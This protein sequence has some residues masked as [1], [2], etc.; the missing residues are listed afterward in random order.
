MEASIAFVLM[1]FM[2][3]IT[4]KYLYNEPKKPKDKLNIALFALFFFNVIRKVYYICNHCYS[5]D[6]NVSYLIVD[7]PEIEPEKLR[8]NRCFLGICC[9]DLFG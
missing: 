7:L 6:I 9:Q 3:Y 5:K 2:L 8:E 1:V 4:C